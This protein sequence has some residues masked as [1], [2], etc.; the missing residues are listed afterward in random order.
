[1]VAGRVARPSQV[2]YR[3]QPTQAI[4]GALAAMTD[5]IDIGDRF[6]RPDGSKPTYRVVRKVAFDQHPP[7]VIL[8]SENADRRTIT[9]G[10]SVL[11]DRRQWVRAE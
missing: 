11:T 2:G 8:E 1:M 6:Q 3:S 10:V 7:H 5:I 9:I 4:Q